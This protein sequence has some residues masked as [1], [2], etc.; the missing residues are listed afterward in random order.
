MSGAAPST[1]EDEWTQ[2]SALFDELADASQSRIEAQLEQCQHSDRIKD[3]VRRMLH[4]QQKQNILDRSVDQLAEQ[5]LSEPLADIHE[6]PTDLL[7]HRFGAWTISKE[8]ARGGMGAV[9]LAQRSDGQFEKTAALKLIK[10]GLYSEAT[11][12]RFNAEMRTLAQLEHPNIARLIDG[13]ISE[14]AIPYFVMEYV[15]GM[16]ITAYADQNKLNLADRA[17]LL[18]QVCAAVEHAHRNLIVHGDLKPSNILVNEQGQ[19]RLVDFGI[20]RSFKEE[21]TQA[22]LPRFTPQYAAPEQV[23][24]QPLTTASD[25]FGLCAVL[26][27]L[28]CGVAPRPAQA[29]TTVSALSADLDTPTPSPLEQFQQSERSDEIADQRQTKVR[30]LQQ[31][32]RGDL[33]WILR[34][35]LAC[36]PTGRIE[37]V[38]Q[39][40]QEL[41][42]WLGGY[43]I[44]A[45]RRAKGY[46]LRRWL[47]RHQ[48]PVLIGVIALAGLSL[49]GL[50]LVE[51]KRL[52]Q[53]QAVK[54]RWSNQFLLS[55]FEQA[56]PILNQQRPITVNRLTEGAAQT[57][58]DQSD[59]MAADLQAA[60]IDVLAP[61]VRDL[62]QFQLAAKLTEQQL[63]LAQA[64]GGKDAVASALNDHGESLT[65]LDQLAQAAE[66]FAQSLVINPLTEPVNSV[67]ISAAQ[68]RAMLL[69]R[70][71]E[72]T[73]AA[74]L[75]DSLLALE[76][77]IAATD[78]GHAAL[79]LIYNTLATIERDRDNLT[80]ALAAVEQALL[81]AEQVGINT[82][83]YADSLASLAAI[84][85]YF[86]NAQ[87]AAEVDQQVVT[88]FEA[89]YGAEH[90]LAIQAKSDLAVSLSQ[91]GEMAKALAMNEAVLAG[92]RATLGND[93]Q[94]V[95]GTLTNIGAAHR[96]LGN[97]EQAAI[98]Y[99]ESLSIWPRLSSPP[100]ISIAATKAGYGRVL[101]E[102]G[103]YTEGA[104]IFRQSLAEIATVAGVDSG[105]HARVRCFYGT[106]LVRAGRLTEAAEIL[107]VAYAK[108][109]AQYGPDS[110]R[111]AIA[112]IPL[113]ELRW[114]QDNQQLAQELAA[115]AVPILDAAGLRDRHALELLRL[116]ELLQRTDT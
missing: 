24:G 104:E 74:N 3:L 62:G 76:S 55:I 50:G 46:R 41:E 103:R 89:L 49:S 31:K 17:R 12:E 116:R 108:V 78:G 72:T 44:R 15:A 84:H 20:A 53:S 37:S 47:A 82:R 58:L 79:A 68:Q 90:A 19:V 57:L 25:V 26:Y 112:S 75:V 99:Q 101:S 40:R 48:I 65:S 77:S 2:V 33:A 83:T 114:A 56:D 35:G 23:T 42:R 107:P 59:P 29:T 85:S 111:T 43:P 69:A 98:A 36:E 63:E 14:Q 113:A 32:L 70:I 8:L 86:G 1:S 9:F 39:L 94:S 66:L 54:A 100:P 30:R 64:Q 110:K 92:Y 6:M 97:F 93:N 21:L 5:L 7:D 18:C 34:Q 102:L 96:A 91:L 27:E 67:A 4:A 115:K 87:A 16:P 71:S 60:A 52:A 80:G 61:I 28:C 10:P 45:R 51:Q 105:L 106:L 11:A 88:A 22:A 73:A 13:G 95:A 38:G 109:L 81:Y